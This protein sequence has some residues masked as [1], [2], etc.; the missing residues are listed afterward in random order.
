MNDESLCAVLSWMLHTRWYVCVFTW[1]CT[2]ILCVCVFD[3]VYMSVFDSSS[4]ECVHVH[5]DE[6]ELACRCELETNARCA[7]T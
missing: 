7:Y 1:S 3:V 2:R 6:T 4:D 5:D